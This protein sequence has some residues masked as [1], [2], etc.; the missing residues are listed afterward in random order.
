MTK[1]G[2]VI[3]LFAITA[4][5]LTLPLTAQFVQGSPA[6]LESNTKKATAGVFNSSVDDFIDTRNW[7]GVSFDKWFGFA[8]GNT[9]TGTNVMGG[10]E[11][12]TIYRGSLGYARKVGSLYLGA[13]YNGNILQI[14]GDGSPTISQKIEGTDDDDRQTQTETITTT[15]YNSAWVNSAN[16]LSLLIGVVGMGFKVGFF[17]SFAADK[18][19]AASG[20]SRAIKVTDTKDGFIKY[21][22]ETVD[23]KLIGG[24]LRPSLSW[25]AAFN[26]VVTIK[27]YVDLALDIYQEEKIDSYKDYTA[28]NGH[29][30]GSEKTNYQGW[31]KGY[32]E[33][34]AAVGA[35]L[36]L[37]GNSAATSTVGI[38]YGLNFKV[39]NNS[40]DVA[41]ISGNARGKVDW[42]YGSTS[43]E[44]TI[45]KTTTSTE[46]NVW[47]CDTTDW[48]HVLTPSYKITGELASGF[49]LGLR[50]TVPV[51]LRLETEDRYAERQQIDREVYNN[52]NQAQNTTTTTLTRSNNSLAETT[53]V[54][55]APTVGLGASYKLIPNRFT[56]NA[57]IYAVPLSYK[58][59]TT[60]RS[61]NG[62]NSITTEKKEDGYGVTISD[63]VTVDDPAYG[64]D[65]VEC[66]ETWAQFNGSVRAGFEFEFTPQLALDLY[67]AYG[68]DFDV[69]ISYFN[70][71]FSVKF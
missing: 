16:Q 7:P 31:N 35:D 49:K 19:P 60:K 21:E 71:L 37:P 70:V 39:Y 4:M 64:A 30:T 17:E 20:E 62:V 18:N 50:V 48:N 11:N 14:K 51:G 34:D 13:W 38:K 23:Y 1:A 32:L 12:G 15:T 69:N 68:T 54:T 6:S 25:G 59:M 45:A 61:P 43:V 24:H 46:A 52:I 29:L 53:T 3:V 10:S 28:Y 5:A 56:I 55:V 40:Y 2:K 27:P 8:T 36:V 65:I 47:F 57:G 9:A 41:D 63:T 44:Q 26:S 42:Y 58:N 33:P 22:N 66:T 67:A